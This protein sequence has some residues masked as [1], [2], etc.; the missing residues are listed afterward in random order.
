MTRTSDA[1]SKPL[2]CLLVSDFT[3]GGLAPILSAHAPS[4][5][6]ASV[7]APF[8]QVIPLLLDGNHACWQPA[9]EVAVIWT[10]PQSVIRSFAAVA[11]GESIAL[12]Q[13]LSEVDQFAEH[14]RGAAS[15]AHIVIVPTW[16]WP[17][18]DRGLGMLNL[19]PA[20]GP[21]YFLMRMNTRLVDQLAG[22][23]NVHLLDAARWVATVGAG[24]QHPKLWHLGKIAFSPEVLTEA[25][26]DIKAVVRAVRGL[27][28]K[29]VLV[30]LDDTLWGGIVGEVGWRNLD[31]GGHSPIG[32]SFV[33]FQRAL[34]A[35]TRRGVVLGIVS[36]NTEEV[37]L[38]A[39]DSHPEMILKR[40]DFAGWRINWRDKAEN[41]A[42]LVDEL[43]LGLASVVFIDD[44]PAERARVRAALPDVLTPE[45]PADR[46]VYEKSLR[47][48]DCF[49]APYIGEE[50]RARTGMYVAERER[51]YLQ[52]SVQS[53]DEYLA[54]LDLTVT[55]EPVDGSNLKRAAQLLNKTN[56]MN[57]TTR[58]L[59]EAQFREWAGAPQNYMRLFRVADKYGDYGLTGIASF[60][61]Q[62]DTARV[63]DFLLSCRVMGREVEKV[64][65]TVLA[66][67]ARSNGLDRLLAEYG[68]TD[69]NA[70]CLAFF[71]EQSGFTREGE[72]FTWRL[73]QPYPCPAHVAIQAQTA[74]DAPVP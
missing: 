12:E 48:L 23:S 7:V 10:R 17:S 25:A 4:P 11:G 1:P 45:W 60:T 18:Y 44:S 32:E 26:I 47:Q 15:R 50:D 30:D 24:A 8:D 19:N 55:H 16:T 41:I 6:M 38:E 21:G 64:M 63:T 49:D 51:R 58:R 74:A 5:D 34:K 53:V 56:Q 59:P 14:V 57:L 46:L 31:L 67:A 9:P 43:N 73:D 72:V 61:I 33:A 40:A 20:S 54:S 66:E 13:V 37:A 36:K 3:I 71:A 65:L 2:R 28:R 22:L 35:L 70:P 69:R 62:G 42:E 52:T 39:I 27:A 29:L 68:P